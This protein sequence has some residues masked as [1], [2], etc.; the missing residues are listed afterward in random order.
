MAQ[1]LDR[2][3]AQAAIIQALAE[4]G[5][6]PCPEVA[7]FDEDAAA[8]ACAFAQTPS[9][10]ADGSI[11]LGGAA[12][13]EESFHFGPFEESKT[14]VTVTL[15]LDYEGGDVRRPGVLRVEWTATNVE[16]WFIEICAHDS[17]R[18]LATRLLEFGGSGSTVLTADELGFDPCRTLWRFFFGLADGG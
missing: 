2:G 16:S 6:L 10:F 14:T 7:A 11:Q 13:P 17:D 9:W 15:H 4:A 12:G 18:V 3:A 1:R 8:A 5:I